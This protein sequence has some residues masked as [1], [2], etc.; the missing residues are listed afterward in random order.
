MS[1]VKYPF[2]ISYLPAVKSFV[3][4]RKSFDDYYYLYYYEKTLSKIN[5]MYVE[6]LIVKAVKQNAIILLKI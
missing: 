6:N 4:I 2:V 3:R 1:L 5:I